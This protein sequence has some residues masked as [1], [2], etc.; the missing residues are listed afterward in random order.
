MT[1]KLSPQLA[2]R[3]LSNQT[4]G[5]FWSWAYSDITSNRNRGI[6]AE[7]LVA[8]ALQVTESPRIEWDAYDLIYGRHKIEV[9]S[10]GYLQSWEQLQSSLI[11]FDIAPKKLWDAKTN[12]YS[13]VPGRA[14]DYYVFCLHNE[15]D[16]DSAD[17]L[18]VSRWI[19][20]IVT[21]EFLDTQFPYQKTI[22]LAAVQ[23]FC[24][25]VQFHEIKSELDS[26]IER[27]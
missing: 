21:T 14:A 10:A 1:E 7:F 16:P 23:T 18:D 11:R 8:T 25:Q 6:F 24:S 20:F 4:V 5:D 2:I 9:K 22:G 17:V 12:T 3:N 13:D 15:T 27:T 19:F 26:I